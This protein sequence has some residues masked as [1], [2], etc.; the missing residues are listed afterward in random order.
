MV[1]IFDYG[2]LL[3]EMKRVLILCTGNSCRS[4]FAEAMVNHFRG[5]KWQA[6]SAGTHPSGYVHPLALRVLE[7]IGIYHSGTSKSTDQ[8]RNVDF[9][10]VITVCDDAAENCPVWLGKG[11]RVHIGFPDPASA[12]GTDDEKMEVFR[13]VRDDIRAK[14]LNYLDSYLVGEI[15]KE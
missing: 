8:F 7:E 14:I 15:I 9:D 4:Q 10:V 12:K 11:K 6:C 5:D 3:T 2:D 1:S 13:Q